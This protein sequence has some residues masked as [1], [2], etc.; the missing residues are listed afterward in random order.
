M[1]F[2]TV[3][4]SEGAAKLWKIIKYAKN[5]A[6]NEEKPCSTR[7]LKP[8][9][10]SNSWYPKIKFHV[11]DASLLSLVKN[12][13]R[14]YTY[15]EKYKTKIDGI[16]VSLRESKFIFSNRNLKRFVWWQINT[17]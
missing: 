14:K 6:K 9:F 1:I 15:V 12:S 11:P 13:K 2:Q 7:C 8:I 10:S 5:L 3:E 17:G 4:H 16:L